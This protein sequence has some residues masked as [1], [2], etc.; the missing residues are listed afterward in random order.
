[1]KTKLNKLQDEQSQLAGRIAELEAEKKEIR[2]KMVADPMKT[3]QALAPSFAQREIQIE[4]FQ[5]KLADVVKQIEAERA[6]IDSPEVQKGIKQAEKIIADNKQ[7]SGKIGAQLEA[8]LSEVNSAM[9][10]ANQ[11]AALLRIGGRDESAAHAGDY[12]ELEAV[13][14]MLSVLTSARAQQ[15]IYTAG[16]KAGQAAKEAREK[17]KAEADEKAKAATKKSI[18]SGGF[19]QAG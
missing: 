3:A 10:K 2:Q 18:L 7:L 16:V 13:K 6:R 14:Q 12:M 1:M 5:E 19:W 11:A 4:V 9:A 17:A 15:G 8:I